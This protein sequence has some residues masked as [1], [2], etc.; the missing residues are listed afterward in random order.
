MGFDE[1]RERTSDA[2]NRP[3]VGHQF[4]DMYSFFVYVLHVDRYGGPVVVVEAQPP[5]TLPQDGN[6]RLFDTADDYRQ[7]YRYKGNTPGYWVTYNGHQNVAGWLETGPGPIER[8][9]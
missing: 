3:E 9:A 2:F 1:I 6:F 7:A 8:T 5:C 4:H